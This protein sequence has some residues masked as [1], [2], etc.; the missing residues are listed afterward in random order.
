M[1]NDKKNLEYQG[2]FRPEPF[3]G[4][5]YEVMLD[6]IQTYLEELIKDINEPICDCPYCGGSG[7][8]LTKGETTK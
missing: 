1:S 4:N 5:N 7:V 6:N 3:E 2:A 8:I